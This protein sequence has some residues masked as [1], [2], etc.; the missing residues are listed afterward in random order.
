MLKREKFRATY[1]REYHRQETEIVSAPGSRAR[2][3]FRPTWPRTGAPGP[4]VPEAR[5]LCHRDRAYGIAEYRQLRTLRARTTRRD[6][7]RQLRDDPARNFGAADRIR[8]SWSDS[9]E[10]ARNWSTL[11]HR[12]S[13]RRKSAS[14]KSISR[15]THPR[16]DDVMNNQ[17]EGRLYLSQ[18]SHRHGRSA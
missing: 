10:E 3:R 17:R 7:L 8:K 2:S 6:R 1:E 5:P 11:A 4:G 13:R 18:R 12:R 9:A 14:N 15:A 16:F